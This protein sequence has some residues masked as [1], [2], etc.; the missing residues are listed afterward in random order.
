MEI[1]KYLKT[2]DN[3]NITLQNLWGAA[4]AE[5]RRRLIAIQAFLKR[6]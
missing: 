2:Y 4:K 6:R 3:E 5:F 1:R